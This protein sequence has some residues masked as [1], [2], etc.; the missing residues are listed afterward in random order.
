MSNLILTPSQR[1]QA[2]SDLK[3]LKIRLENYLSANPKKHGFYHFAVI[4]PPA[5]LII[6][7]TGYYL[8]KA[9]LI[10][11]V[12]YTLVFSLAYYGAMGLNG[13]LKPRW[14]DDQISPTDLERIREFSFFVKNLIVN[15]MEKAGGKLTYTQLE[16]VAKEADALLKKDEI[17]AMVATQLNDGGDSVKSDW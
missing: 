10:V 7:P 3:A 17:R 16:R 4:V 1:R 5:L 13:Y 2:Q 15:S 6:G 8:M 11:G 12:I 14:K 9:S